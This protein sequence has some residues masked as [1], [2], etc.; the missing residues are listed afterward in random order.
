M[1]KS[2]LTIIPAAFVI[3]LWIFLFTQ[4]DLLAGA[5]EYVESA[6]TLGY[7]VYIMVIIASSSVLP[8]NAMLFIPLGASVMDPAIIVIL[9]IIGWIIGATIA[10]L[11]AR[12]FGRRVLENY[13]SF[14]RLDE[15]MDR[16]PVKKRFLFIVLFRLVLPTDLASYALGFS[17]SLGFMEYFGATL[18][19]V[20]WYSFALTYLGNALVS[21]QILLAFKLALGLLVIF[22]IGWYLLRQSKN[23]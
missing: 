4:K 18:I 17:K 13:M 1:K 5:T 12:H 7:L 19:A 20:V 9:S 14:D 8:L 23:S 10:F 22:S 11:L 15:F 2:L 6:G 3:A 21:G 16:F